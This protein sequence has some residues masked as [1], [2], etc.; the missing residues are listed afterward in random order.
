MQDWIVPDWP[1]PYNVH[2]LFTTRNGGVSNGSYA[3]FNLGNHVNDSSSH[4]KQNRLLLCEHLPAEPIWLN[5]V[6]GASPIWVDDET[7]SL[8]GD[9]ALSCGDKTVCAVMVADCLPIFLCDLAGTMVGV[10]HAGWRGL[11]AGIIEKTLATINYENTT[12]MAW[13]G[14]AIGPSH[15]EVGTEVRDI[16]VRHDN[17]AKDAFVPHGNN[18]WLANIFVLA[19]QRLTAV[20]LTKIY[21]NDICTF[22]DPEKFFSYRREGETGRM[23]A[24]IWLD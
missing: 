10:I 12:L 22:S 20:G 15:F 18:K 8:Q 5:Q 14:P 3:T 16:F 17:R 19:Y 9:A 13:F 11:Y 21:S 4:V 23:A 7:V 24:L 1:A 6:H 2:A